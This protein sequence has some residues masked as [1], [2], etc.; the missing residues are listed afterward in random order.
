[1]LFGVDLAETRHVIFR[2]VDGLIA[3]VAANDLDETVFVIVAPVGWPRA[4]LK[5]FLHGAGLRPPVLRGVRLSAFSFSLGSLA[6]II[7]QVLDHQTT[8][9]PPYCFGGALYSTPK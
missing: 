9:K 4:Q 6:D 5:R 2:W 7:H 1:M 3:N 8:N